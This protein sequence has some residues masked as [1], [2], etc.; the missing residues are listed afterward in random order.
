MTQVASTCRNNRASK[1][2]GMSLALEQ[3]VRGNRGSAAEPQ[4]L[5]QSRKTEC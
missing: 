1:H 5:A 3:S 4:S 2:A